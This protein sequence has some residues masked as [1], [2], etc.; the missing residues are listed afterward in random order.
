MATMAANKPRSAARKLLTADDLLDL[1][2]KGIRGELIRGELNETMSTG[3]EHGEV[4]S[5][6]NADLVVFTRRDK[7]GRVV[8]SDAGVLLERD[9][10][11]VRE[12]DIAFFAA[13]KFQRGERV[14]GYSEVVPDLVV[15]VAS[16]RDSRSALNDKAM[17]WLTYGVRMV[18][19][20]HPD[21]RAIDVHRPG[22]RVQRLGEHDELDGLDVLPGFT[23][24]VSQVFDSID[25]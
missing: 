25:A 20:A 14:G 15:E 8:A 2:S 10:Y 9:P 21:L 5:N 23:C 1:Y 22:Q 11:T 6:L 4:V 12:P 16:P 17:M 7:L 18:W 13:E 24:P 19:V 3:Q